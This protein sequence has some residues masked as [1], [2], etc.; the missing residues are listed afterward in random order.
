MT[1]II[2]Y[3][4]RNTE[5]KYEKLLC[6]KCNHRKRNDNNRTAFKCFINVVTFFDYKNNECKYFEKMKEV[7]NE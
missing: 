4:W 7:K 3:E 5:K 2:P 6:T 1:Q